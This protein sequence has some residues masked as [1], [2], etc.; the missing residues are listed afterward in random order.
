MG[1]ITFTFFLSLQSKELC[2]YGKFLTRMNT[3]CFHVLLVACSRYGTPSQLQELVD[4]AHRHGL[5]VLLDVV[6]SHAS[7]NVEDGLNQF[8]GSNTC[9]FHDG[10][11]GEHSL[12]DSRL[13]DYSKYVTLGPLSLQFAS[14]SGPLL[15]ASQQVSL[16]ST[17]D[18]VLYFVMLICLVASPCAAP[19]CILTG[20]DPIPKF[21]SGAAVLIFTSSLLPFAMNDGLG[22]RNMD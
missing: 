10:G 18:H 16:Q 5:V 14:A 19:R 20:I 3:R 6:H 15:L 7:K 17:L 22:C 21:A 8:D 12:W 4:T 1:F 2:I 11:R 13:F 9:Y